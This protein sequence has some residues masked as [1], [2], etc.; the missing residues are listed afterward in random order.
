MGHDLA[1]L[2]AMRDAAEAQIRNTWM[3]IE[4]L[5]DLAIEI[6]EIEDQ[7]ERLRKFQDAEK[8]YQKKKK[9]AHEN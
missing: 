3:G 2:C 9:A 8:R 6:K 1:T 5:N 4:E 7:I